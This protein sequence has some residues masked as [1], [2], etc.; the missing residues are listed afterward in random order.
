MF[1]K[2]FLSGS[3]CSDIWNFIG[4]MALH[5]LL[6]SGGFVSYYTKKIITVYVTSAHE[7]SNPFLLYSIIYGLATLW[8]LQT[9]APHVLY[10]VFHS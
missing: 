9:H 4:Q 1:K 7:V 8:S 3:K 10:P 2:F 5:D 6:E